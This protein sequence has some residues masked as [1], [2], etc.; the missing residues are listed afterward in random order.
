M[1]VTGECVPG[2]GNSD[3]MVREARLALVIELKERAT[4]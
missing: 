2:G 4:F 1:S 3:V